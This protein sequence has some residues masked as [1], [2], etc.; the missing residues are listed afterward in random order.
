MLDEFSATSISKPQPTSSGPGRPSVSSTTKSPIAPTDAPSTEDELAGDF[1]AALQK[2]M[3]ALMGEIDESP[4]MKK[5]LDE[6]MASLST[7]AAEKLQD[8]KEGSEGAAASGKKAESGGGDSGSTTGPEEAFTE[9]IRRTMERMQASGEQASAAAVGSGPG[10][11]EDMLSQLLKEMASGSGEGGEED[12]SKMLLGMMEQ[13]T[14]K[15]ILYEPM[16]ELHD[17][18]PGWMKKN[19]GKVKAEDM[20]RYKEQQG[21]VAEIVRRFER[22][23]YSDEDAGDREFIVERMQKVSGPDLDCCDD[24]CAGEEGKGIVCVVW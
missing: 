13:L 11:E 24:D 14:N 22:T 3:A 23:G 16:K 20:A 7:D 2:E 6:M 12:F 17:K 18:F 15:E 21:L 9:T 19:E 4:E 8:S 1:S 5:Q 10:G